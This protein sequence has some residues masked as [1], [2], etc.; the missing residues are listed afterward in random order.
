MDQR[1]MTHLLCLA[2]I[3]RN[4]ILV[5]NLA[6]LQLV[7]IHITQEQQDVFIA[8]TLMHMLTNCSR[9]L[10]HLFFLVNNLPELDF[11][12]VCWSQVKHGPAVVIIGFHIL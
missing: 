10:L 9:N 6:N 3:V 7:A 2:K 8:S 11:F 1:M 12:L 5:K 4:I